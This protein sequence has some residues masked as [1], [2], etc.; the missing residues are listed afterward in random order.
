MARFLTLLLVAVAVAAILAV[1]DES[2][3]DGDLVIVK[4]LMG[5][6]GVQSTMSI[7]LLSSL[8]Y[9]PYCCAKTFPGNRTNATVGRGNPHSTR[10]SR[11]GSRPGRMPFILIDSLQNILER[12]W[13]SVA[14]FV[15][16]AA[17][18]TVCDESEIIFKF[19]YIGFTFHTYA[20]AMLVAA[21]IDQG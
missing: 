4:M 9:L 8:P 10:M 13:Q 17:S 14:H 6:G 15:R 19:L 16:R 21:P 5:V 1:D 11:I 3:E 20:P 7:K 18:A 12:P 2:D